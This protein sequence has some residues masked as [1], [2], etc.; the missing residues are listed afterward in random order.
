[1]LTSQNINNIN[2]ERNRVIPC[3]TIFCPGATPFKTP[4]VRREAETFKSYVVSRD[5]DVDMGNNIAQ[6]ELS[7]Q[8]RLQ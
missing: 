1:M 8:I 6:S 2:I 4:K 3:L 7:G 5:D